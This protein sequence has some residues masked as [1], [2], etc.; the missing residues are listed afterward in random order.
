MFNKVLFGFGNRTNRSQNT[1]PSKTGTTYP[2]LT[3]RNV[4]GSHRTGLGINTLSIN[5]SG[6]HALIAGREIFKTIRVEGNSCTE[7]INIRA[8]IRSHNVTSNDVNISRDDSD[9]QDVAWAK[10]TT[11]NFVA[12]AT[13][14][15]PIILYD[16]NRLGPEI[17]RLF[18]HKRQIHR[19]TFN[20]HAGHYM[21]SASHDGT[22]KL[23]DI[24]DCQRSVNTFRSRASTTDQR[25]SIRDVKWSPTNGT[26]F[27]FSTDGGYIQKWDTQMMRTHKIKIPAHSGPCLAID[28]HPDGKHLL[29]AGGDKSARVWNVS[30]DGKKPGRAVYDIKM[31]HPL[32]SAKWR[33]SFKSVLHGDPDVRQCTQFVT[34]YE[35]DY[36]VLHIWDVRRPDVPFRELDRDLPTAPT[37]VQWHSQDL[38]WTVSREGIFMQS[39]VS[40]APKVID[41]RNLQATAMS[42]Q[43]EVIVVAQTRRPT[44]KTY[45]SAAMP[46]PDKSDGL[47]EE[48]G[49]EQPGFDVV[50][51]ADDDTLDDNFLS[52]S[53]QMVKRKKSATPDTIE[54]TS[55][56]LT[57]DR[58]LSLDAPMDRFQPVRPRQYSGRCK[59][60]GTPDMAGFM[61]L[62]QKYKLRSIT[63]PPTVDALQ[64]IH[65]VFDQNGKYADL[66][67]QYRLAASWRILGQL[68]STN[69]QHRAKMSQAAR[70]RRNS[71]A[72]PLNDNRASLSKVIQQLL[73]VAND[74]RASIP[75]TPHMIPVQK[76]DHSL[77]PRH[78]GNSSTSTPKVRAIQTAHTETAQHLPIIDLGESIHRSSRT[79]ET[80]SGRPHVVLQIP[81]K[82]E[83]KFK[84]DAESEINRFYPKHVSQNL[85][86]DLETPPLLSKVD[87]DD[88]FGVFPLMTGYENSPLPK[89]AASEQSRPISSVNEFNNQGP[90][91][92]HGITRRGSF[93]RYLHRG[94]H[95]YYNSSHSQL[96]EH[97]RQSGMPFPSR[98]DTSVGMTQSQV[99]NPP[100]V[101]VAERPKV[102]GDIHQD[103]LML[104][105]NNQE[106]FASETDL[107]L[108]SHRMIVESNFRKAL[109]QNS[110]ASSNDQTTEN[111]DDDDDDYDDVDQNNSQKDEVGTLFNPNH[112]IFVTRGKE[113]DYQSPT[114][115]DR[116]FRVSDYLNNNIKDSS[117]EET[118]LPLVELMRQLIYYH[119]TYQ[120]DTQSLAAMLLMVVPLLP[121]NH[122]LNGNVVQST[123]NYY[124]DHFT[125]LD[126]ED[127]AI[128]AILDKLTSH[129]LLAGL[130]PIQLESIFVT[131]H[132][133]LLSLD[134]P[135]LAAMQRRL[136]YPTFPTVY[137]MA[138]KDN[139]M[140]FRCS[141]CSKPIY[142]ASPAQARCESCLVRPPQCP[143][144]WSPE[145]PYEDDRRRAKMSRRAMST[146]D[147]SN[148]DVAQ[149]LPNDKPNVD[150]SPEKVKVKDKVKIAKSA[151]CMFT[152]CLTCNHVAHTACLAVWHDLEEKSTTVE[153]SKPKN[154][155]SVHFNGQSDEILE[156]PAIEIEYINRNGTRDSR[157]PP[158]ATRLHTIV[159]RESSN[160]WHGFCPVEGCGCRCIA[161]EASL[162]LQPIPD[163]PTTQ[164]QVILQKQSEQL[165]R[166][167]AQKM[168]EQHS[169]ASNA[170]K[171]HG[172]QMQKVEQDGHL[173]APL[174]AME[175]GHEQYSGSNSGSGIS[176]SVISGASNILPSPSDTVSVTGS[177]R[178]IV[179][180]SSGTFGRRNNP[181]SLLIKSSNDFAPSSVGSMGSLNGFGDGSR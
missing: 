106:S 28:W 35:K 164:R 136:A 87:S 12:A 61:Y 109:V 86:N 91:T 173:S 167:Y 158:S 77:L 139:Q 122:L 24:R 123:V 138:L 57:K 171:Q 13:R 8:A 147:Q 180:S 97:V 32:R 46:G 37:S 3:A 116:Q 34:S 104:A 58:T 83:R 72:A 130:N 75:S 15:G 120:S 146:A 143:I 98:I 177:E 48:D 105:R 92:G 10:G 118:L 163:A 49:G 59:I 4:T 88:S 40:F 157:L 161:S 65:Y 170:V 11:A 43:G 44:V 81:D 42:T 82:E 6:T 129:L 135:V 26:E 117:D 5:E 45:Q 95:S 165:N 160:D 159:Q 7:D 107:S 119:T 22:V 1:K 134:M 174:V 142:S 166:E 125:S 153:R 141:S 103:M 20:P 172:Q 155:N 53:V 128:V 38:L 69:L 51:K 66:A 9:I 148:S 47:F 17:A 71:I 90:I 64:N 2:V 144:C 113:V 94:D 175:W 55:Q 110:G 108:E 29:S 74:L 179:G 99:L 63:D 121:E 36:P 62:A 168:Q 162:L 131:Y 140:S 137:E 78:G 70:I 101:A 151:A 31:P 100:A 30:G 133:Q 67:S 76:P 18:E 80:D 114:A 19:V 112:G 96:Q 68:V 93:E 33:P 115:E 73:A 150:K 169:T 39:D 27:A 16:L 152:S 132:D 111:D 52:A 56:K 84:S 89:S 60:P 124:I 154:E 41:R 127:S 79:E 149:D 21:L 14:S 176:S 102:Q 85:E 50:R 145:S 181:T 178:R 126:F 54:T 23:W 25:E 156:V